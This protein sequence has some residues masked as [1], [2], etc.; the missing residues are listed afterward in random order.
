MKII[1]VDLENSNQTPVIFEAEFA[2]P[3]K[4]V[5]QGQDTPRQSELNDPVSRGMYCLHSTTCPYHL[6]RPNGGIVN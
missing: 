1:C 5:C 4:E 6:I 3:A 2:I